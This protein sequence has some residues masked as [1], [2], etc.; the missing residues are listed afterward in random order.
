MRQRERLIKKADR[1]RGQ[2][3]LIKLPD[4]RIQSRFQCIDAQG[5]DALLVKTIPNGITISA[6]LFCQ[7][8]P[9]PGERFRSYGQVQPLLY[10]WLDQQEGTVSLPPVSKMFFGRN[11]KIVVHFVGKR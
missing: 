11:V 4:D 9:E 5:S 6:V 2:S 7:L 10:R 8:L 1:F 3:V